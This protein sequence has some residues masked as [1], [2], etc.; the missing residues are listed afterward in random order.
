MTSTLSPGATTEE[1]LN[2]SSLSA[3]RYWMM[4][5]VMLDSIPSGQD[6]LMVMDVGEASSSTMDNIEDS[7]IQ[8]EKS[9]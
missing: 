5:P 6:Q 3:G 7:E 2:S 8:E 4:K 1:L 9:F